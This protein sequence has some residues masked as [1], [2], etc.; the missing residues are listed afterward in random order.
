[1]DTVNSIYS[2]S[3]LGYYVLDTTFDGNRTPNKDVTIFLIS[4]SLEITQNF[5]LA[6]PQDTAVFIVNG[7]I[8]IDGEVTRIPGLYISSQTFSIAEGDQP[9]IFDGMV[10]AKNI[11]FQRKYYSFTNPAYTFIYQPKYVIDLLPYL[12]RPQV[13]WQ[14]VSP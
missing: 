11:N 4:G 10:Y 2:Y 3:G 7:N 6:D 13:N 5:T 1:M 14:E 12:G 8:Y 9:I